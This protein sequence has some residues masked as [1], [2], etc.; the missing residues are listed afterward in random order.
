MAA[1]RARSCSFSACAAARRKRLS[2]RERRAHS[3]LSS[4]WRLRDDAVEASE[5]DAAAADSDGDACAG[6]ASAGDAEREVAA[7]AGDEVE[8]E[9]IE[10]AILLL[11]LGKSRVDWWILEVVCGQE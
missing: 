1:M 7:E 3:V 11:L 10:E 2:A 8:Y 5:S 6:D 9:A 4:C